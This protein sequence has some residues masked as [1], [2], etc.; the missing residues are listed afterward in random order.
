M[1]NKTFEYGIRKT[2]MQ[3]NHWLPVSLE[4]YKPEKPVVLVLGGLGT[5][6][7]R[8]ANGNAK[9]VQTM[10]GIFR[11]KVDL[12]SVN[13]NG[14]TDRAEVF[15]NIKYLVNN[16]FIKYVS[17]DGKRLDTVQAC[18]NMRQVCVFAHCYGAYEILASAEKYMQHKFAELGYSHGEVSNILKQ[19]VCIS[20][21]TYSDLQDITEINCVSTEDHL[22]GIY[23]KSLWNDIAQVVYH[24][25]QINMTEE[26]K[27]AL[28]AAH[29][30]LACFPD[31]FLKDRPRC[32]AY[33]EREHKLCIATPKLEVGG[34]DHGTMFLMRESKE[35]IA[36]DAGDH[37]T[38][39]YTCVLREAVINSIRNTRTTELVEFDFDKIQKEI[40]HI[41]NQYNYGII[42]ERE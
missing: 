35:D 42:K 33:K 7:E 28:L 25:G 15:E 12:L 14:I 2:Y 40:E 17:K 39:A 29:T 38:Q 16:F 19:I 30:E 5:N 18:K 20:H 37:I 3:P 13:C 36:T 24:G 11:D 9:P 34:Q 32:F 6:S 8:T 21:G 41:L 10:L 4:T 26:D 22:M 27:N 1:E 23:G 31:N